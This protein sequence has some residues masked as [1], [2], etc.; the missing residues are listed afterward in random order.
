[1]AMSIE[2]LRS[3]LP[4][5]AKDIGL[6]LSSIAN[7]ERLGA[8]T[9][10]GLLLAAAAATRNST[11]LAAIEAEAGAALSPTARDAALAAASIMAMN[12]VY[13]RF[14]HL[15]ADKAYASMPAKLRM[16]VLANPGVAKADFELWC[17]AVSA[18]NGCG[19]CIDAHEK[20]LVEAGVGREVVQTAVRYA[21]I[22]QAAAVALEAASVVSVAA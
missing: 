21:A 14:V 15:A 4:P 8:E 5:F 11:V 1:M 18:I 22:L 20:A 19:A 13:Y 2:A 10:F 9:K 6:N 16:N 17:L 3:R 12:N 7:D